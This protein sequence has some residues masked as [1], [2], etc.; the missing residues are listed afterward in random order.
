MNWE[1]KLNAI[2]MEIVFNHKA[3]EVQKGKCQ[4]N[5]R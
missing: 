5:N 1:F 3:D 2:K 4:K